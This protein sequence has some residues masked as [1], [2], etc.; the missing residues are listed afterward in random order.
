MILFIL[1]VVLAYIL[2]SI[3]FGLIT[4]NQEGLDIREHGSGNIGATNVLRTLGAKAAVITLLG[5]ILKGTFAVLIM[6]GFQGTE[7]WIALAGMAAIAGH[8]WPLFLKFRGGK[9]VATSFGVFLGILPLAALVG[10]GVWLV[11]VGIWR[12]SSLG[13]LISFLGM[14]L[15]IYAFRGS[16]TYIISSALITVLIFYRHRS[17]IKRLVQGTESKLGQKAKV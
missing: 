9:G 1:I 12:Y 10:A 5:D 14:P 11:V 6:K 15:I 16:S 2:G 3:P 17:N 4:A 7:G 13:A 8:N